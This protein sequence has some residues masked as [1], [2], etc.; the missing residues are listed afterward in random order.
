METKT[1]SQ[2][3]TNK[4]RVFIRWILLPILGIFLVAA[5]IFTNKHLV[6]AGI[7]EEVTIPN[8]DIELS[9]VFVKPDTPG[10]HPVIIMLQGSGTRQT[11]NKWHYNIHGNVFLREGIAVLAYDKRGQ[12]DSG[13]DHPT[14]TFADWV[15]DGLAAV[16]YL[17]SRSDV[18]PDQIGLF[19]VSESGWFTPEIA[20]TD[21]NIA[22]ILQRVSTPLTWTNTVLW[23]VEME[24][25][26]RGLT[27]AE[28]EAILDLKARE[29]QYI[30][31]TAHDTSLA[32]GPERDALNAAMVEMQNHEVMSEFFAPEMLPYDPDVYAYRAQKY[33]YDPMPFLQEID[34]PMLYVLGGL[35]VNIPY[36]ATK[37]LLE[38]LIEQG[39][40]IEIEVFP[41][42]NH[43][44]YRWEAFPLEGLYQEGYLELLGSWTAKQVIENR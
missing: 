44:M 11:H 32:S 17:R 15:S 3:N 38:E 23:E 5:A 7:I 39:K 40:P 21:G 29:W 31:D 4:G 14:A 20:A 2:K 41:E 13:G 24:A 6:Y 37:L 1:H 28:V 22:F 10:P 36:E 8:G 42:A 35:D 34:V 9:G 16:E 30:V 27:K 25:R 26:S 12:G 43:Y 33:A 19:G 18:D